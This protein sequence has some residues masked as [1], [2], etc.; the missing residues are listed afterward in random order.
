MHVA[1]VCPSY[2]DDWLLKI[3]IAAAALASGAASVGCAWG[4]LGT[5]AVAV[6]V[7]FSV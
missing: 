3:L 4:V 6:A 7:L 5:A 2:R 1:A